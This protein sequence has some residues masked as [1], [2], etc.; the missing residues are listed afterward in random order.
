ML[1]V[2]CVI[3]EQNFCLA[4]E[5]SAYTTGRVGASITRRAVDEVIHTGS[6]T[7]TQQSNH[8]L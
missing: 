4:T 3:Y 6:E 1:R 2:F 8:V 7:W 5:I